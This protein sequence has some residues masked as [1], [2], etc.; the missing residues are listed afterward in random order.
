MLLFQ[1]LAIFL[2]FKNDLYAIQLN[3]DICAVECFM[4]ILLNINEN[5]GD[6]IPLNNHAL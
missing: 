6:R 3:T 5:N 4:N 2:K 1:R